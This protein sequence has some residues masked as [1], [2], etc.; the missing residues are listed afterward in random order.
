[1]AV[2]FALSL[3]RLIRGARKLNVSLISKAEAE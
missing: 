1:L 2:I 3:S